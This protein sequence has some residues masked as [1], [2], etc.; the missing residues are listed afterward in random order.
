MRGRDV[1]PLGEKK[2]KKKSG[3][4]R[5]SQKKALNYPDDQLGTASR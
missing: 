1:V 4:T 3:V 2:K 5:S